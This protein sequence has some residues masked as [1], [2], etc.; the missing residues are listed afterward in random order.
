M[1]YEIIEEIKECT[2]CDLHKYRKKA[3]PGEG[4]LNSKVL[5]LGEA[6]GRR[7]DEEGRPFVGAAGKLLD[8]LL[9]NIG[10]SREEVF[11]TNVVKCRPPNNRDPRDDEIR[12]CS[13]HT[14][15][16]LSLINPDIIITLGNH[17]GKYIFAI[18]GS[19]PWYGVSKHRSRVYELALNVLGKKVKVIPT[20]HPAAALYN[21]IL[22]RE[23]ESDFML[24]QKVVRSVSEKREGKTL[25]DF[26]G[27]GEE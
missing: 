25:L 13:V 16:I 24:I 12:A 27:G 17:A 19:K 10:L 22:R 14:N 21:P 1:W 3:V 2:R 6:P 23:L 18:L 7:E 8:T 15:R 26:L 20:Y 9:R 11:I 4:S 5:F